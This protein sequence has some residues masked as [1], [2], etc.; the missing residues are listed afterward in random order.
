MREIKFRAWDKYYKAMCE[1]DVWTIKGAHLIGLPVEE[2]TELQSDQKTY[3]TIPAGQRFRKHKQIIL[4]Q[5]TGLH[6]KNGKEIYE[7]DIVRNRQ[8]GV[9]KVISSLDIPKNQNWPNYH[10]WI[11]RSANFKGRNYGVNELFDWS[12]P[13]RVEVIGNIY[14]NPE[15]IGETK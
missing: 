15:L 9:Y 5:F 3:V 1:V 14:E 12:K 4:M 2:K 10:G 11:M 6:D 13:E 7:G 8:G